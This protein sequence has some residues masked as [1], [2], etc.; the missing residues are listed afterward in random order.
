M[1]KGR[2]EESLQ[3]LARLHARGDTTDAFVVA[4]FHEMRESVRREQEVKTGWKQCFNEYQ[5]V[6]KI[7]LGVILQFSVQMT[8]VS[9]LQY[10]S[11]TIFAAIGF[12]VSTT[13]MLQSINTVLGLL[14]EFACVMFIDKTGRRWPMIIGNIICGMTFLVAT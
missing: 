14:G 2:E 1:I 3:T 4:E 6:R 9:A 11:P 13:L 7:M 10:Y 5:S 12:G 8:G